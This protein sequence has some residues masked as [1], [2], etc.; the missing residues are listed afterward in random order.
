[1]SILE[2]LYAELDYAVFQKVEASRFTCVTEPPPW[3]RY[4][5][6]DVRKDE[7]VD[8]AE[9]SPFLE[10]FL[11]DSE[12]HWASRARV[13]SKSG[14]WIETDDQGLELS[15]E[16]T[17]VSV[18]DECILILNS[19]GLEYEQ[20]LQKLQIAREN[21]LT[22]ED[23]ELQVRLRTADIRIREEEIAIRLIAAAGHRDEETGAHIRRIGLYAEEMT[24]VLDWPTSRIDDIKL[25][26]P[27]HDVG[28]IGISDLILH[29]PGVLTDDEYKKMK[30]HA[31]IGEKMLSG[32]GIPMLDLAAEIAGGHHE[33]WDGTGYPRGLKAEEIPQSA[34]I[35]SMLDVYDAL[36]HR[37]VYKDAFSEVKTLEI[38]SDLVGTQFDPRLFEVFL[39]ILDR[40]RDIKDQNPD[41]HHAD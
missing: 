25:A 12:L 13:P 19:L 37:R 17:A 21:L 8:I 32:S 22:Q 35:V 29:K 34:R 23:L 11:V 5:Q 41:D 10:N 7:T 38:M 9:F 40:I 20:Q 16:A 3:F 28:K 2:Q 24:R 31:I 6:A 1:M 36:V 39:S 18:G 26:A 27:M 30:E 14:P 4:F 15:L 33:K